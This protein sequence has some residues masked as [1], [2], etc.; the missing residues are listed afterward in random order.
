MYSLIS[1]GYQPLS[2]R[3]LVLTSCS[4]HACRHALCLL[5]CRNDSIAARHLPLTSKPPRNTSTNHRWY[6]TRRPPAST[7]QTFHL[8]RGQ[9]LRDQCL[10]EAG[11]SQIKKTVGLVRGWC[12]LPDLFTSGDLLDFSHPFLSHAPVMTA[13]LQIFADTSQN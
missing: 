2:T 11:I 12:I 1:W 7:W 10:R 5:S 4:Y 13:S 8:P 6:S 9:D 3:F